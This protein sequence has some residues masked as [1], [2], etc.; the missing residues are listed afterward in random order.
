ML[1]L[2]PQFLK[3][4]AYISRFI[5][6]FRSQFRSFPIL[7]F[8]RKIKLAIEKI[9]KNNAKDAVANVLSGFPVHLGTGYDLELPSSLYFEYCLA[10]VLAH[11]QIML[12]LVIC[13]K[14]CALYF[15]HFL[16][17]GHFIEI[18]TMIIGLLGH[19]W[20]QARQCLLRL[21]GFYNQ[22]VTLGSIFPNKKEFAS[23]EDFPLNLISFIGVDWKEEV[24][25]LVDES[26][27][28]YAS[29]TAFKLISGEQVEQM[30]IAPEEPRK[31]PGN[32]MLIPKAQ[33][34]D[35]GEVI[36]RDTLK[37]TGMPEVLGKR[38]LI[39]FLRAENELRSKKSNKSLTKGVSLFHWEK[40]RSMMEVKLKMA[41][42]NIKDVFD[43][44]WAQLCKQ[45]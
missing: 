42:V 16:Q 2:H 27:S 15:V 28:S 41:N 17:N 14:K 43:R 21:D 37:P 40:F 12:R 36:S 38:T 24:D 29:S 34:S 39:N 32:K 44:E 45:K 9:H 6:L 35:M 10:K 3:N 13:S 23:P 5:K 22:L 25:V 4:T 19:V 1:E 8:M 11:A 31:R 26:T 7:Q 33:E 30:E 20:Q 18:S